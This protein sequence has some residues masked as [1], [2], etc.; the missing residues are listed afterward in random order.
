[1]RLNP[2]FLLGL[3]ATASAS[4]AQ[5]QRQHDAHVHGSAELRLAL[6]AGSLE[7]ELQ[8]PGMDI[9]GFEHAPTEAAQKAA[10]ANAIAYLDSAVWITL[11]SA[12]GCA[13]EKA[14]FHTH[15][16]GAN[17]Q[18]V[19]SGPA[20]HAHGDEEPA[21]YDRQGHGHQHA[22]D[23]AA[24]AHADHGHHADFHGTLRWQCSRPAALAS[25][26]ITL[27]QRFPAISRLTVESIS[28]HGQGRTVL[29]GAEGHVH[30][31]R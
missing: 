16:F 24:D 10:I 12:A 11:P 22:S 9:V 8:A 26:A 18:E 19:E 1:M 4:H 7:I 21:S 20:P 25:I 17:G 27:G 23:G 30:L 2:W 15:G 28:E 3:A 6:E 14:T 29:S 13:L 31:S 5:I